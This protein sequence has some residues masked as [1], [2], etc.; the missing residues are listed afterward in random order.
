MYQK[1]WEIKRAGWDLAIFRLCL[2][3]SDED[4]EFCIKSINSKNAK[5]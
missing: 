1:D 3:P 2:S 5:I 4:Q